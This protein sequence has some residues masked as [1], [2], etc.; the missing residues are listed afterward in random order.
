MLFVIRAGYFSNTGV[1]FPPR[2]VCRLK[3]KCMFDVDILT[4]FVLRMS[5]YYGNCLIVPEINKD[6]G[7]IELL[8]LEK[9]VNLT[10]GRY[11]I[12]EKTA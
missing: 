2:P 7:M 1:W 3:H 12:G 5:R 8:K 4:N 10:N 11:S 9:N 6:R